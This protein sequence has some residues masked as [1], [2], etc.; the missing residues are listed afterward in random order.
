MSAPP[1]EVEPSVQGAFRDPFLALLPN[2]TE[3]VMSSAALQLFIEGTSSSSSS[4]PSAPNQLPVRL[5]S[6]GQVPSLIEALDKTKHKQPWAVGGVVIKASQRS[7]EKKARVDTRASDRAQNTFSSKPSAPSTVPE[8]KKPETSKQPKISYVS[9]TITDLMGAELKL[10]VHKRS[11]AEFQVGQ[12]LLVRNP[13]SYRQVNP[14]THEISFALSSWDPDTELHPVGTM[15][16]LAFCSYEV[17]KKSRMGGEMKGTCGAPID[18]GSCYKGMCATHARVEM[19]KSASALLGGEANTNG[20][21]LS[22][23]K[24]RTFEDAALGLL[25]KRSAAKKA[26][27]EATP[28][29]SEEDLTAKRQKILANPNSSI[30]RRQAYAAVLGVHRKY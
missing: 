12:V 20:D 27:N 14:Y 9:L 29:P 11:K 1:E 19:D 5:V 13:S 6:V 3:R 18:L 7:F 16:T 24:K 21:R 25:A 4:S 17:M 8:A 15:K 22:K 30:A 10:A 26:E 2:D 23:G 28:K